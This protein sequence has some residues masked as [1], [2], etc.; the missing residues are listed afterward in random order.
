M[1]KRA[2]IAALLLTDLAAGCARKADK[3]VASLEGKAITE[4]DFQHHIGVAFPPGDVD[5]IRRSSSR[6]KAALNEYLDRVAIRAKARRVGIDKEPRFTKAVELMEMK[7]LAHL[8]TER[9]RERIE[10]ITQ[11]SPDEVRRFYDEHKAEYTTTPCFTAHHLLVYVRG[12]PAF[13]ERGVSD[14]K[15]RAKAEKALGELRAGAS[16]DVVAKRFSDDLSTNEK[17][18]LIRDG[19]FG[20]FAPEVERAVRT[21]PQDKPGDPVRSMFGYHVL[22]VESRTVERTPERFEEIEPQLRERLSETHAALVHK[23][24]I[25][26]IAQEVGLKVTDAGKRDAFLLDESAM[27]ASEV[28]AEVAGKQILESDF[29]WFLKDALIVRQRA[30]AYSRPGA[31][32]NMLSSFLDMLVLEAKARKEGLDKSAEFV[33]ERYAMEQS[34]LLE[35][36]QERDKAGPFCQ[37]QETPEARQEADRR[38]FASARAEVGLR[39]LGDPEE[40]PARN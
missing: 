19:Q 11:V 24:V 36:M 23:A 16:W 1:P 22:Q 28:L 6:R 9:N 17:G 34:L 25:E 40:F 37:C 35:F 21:Q 31:R 29:R 18:G 38:Y 27:P 5:E 12:N 26:P 32:Q 3:P 14:A 10:R 8:L 7:T 30:A 33:R 4:S 39:V 2:L 20:Y 15:A 13:P